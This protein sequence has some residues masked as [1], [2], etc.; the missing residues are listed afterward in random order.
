MEGIHEQLA[1]GILVQ[2]W[3]CLRARRLSRYQ[4]LES[5][6]CTPSSPL[7]PQERRETLLPWEIHLLSEMH[8]P[9][10][11]HPVWEMHLPWEMH[12][13]WALEHTLWGWGE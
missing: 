8:L 13:C 5:Q 2:L 11:V 3:L 12:L 7:Y 4:A 9:R 6:P 1:L 10:E